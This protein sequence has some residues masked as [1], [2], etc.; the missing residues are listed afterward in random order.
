MDD[1]MKVMMIDDEP[2]VLVHLE[3]LVDWRALGFRLCG[4]FQDC[5][6]A[7]AQ[8]LRDPP[9][10]L[11]IDIS[12]PGISGLD[13]IRKL[14]ETGLFPHTVVLTGFAEFTYVQD[15]LRLGVVDYLLKPLSEMK[16]TSILETLK[17]RG[18][19]SHSVEGVHV[20]YKLKKMLAYI[21]EYYS[22]KLSIQTLSEQFSMSATHCSHLFSRELGKSFS[23]YLL[24]VR[25]A[26]AKALLSD[27]DTAVKSIVEMC[28]Y[29]DYVHFHKTFSKHAGMTPAKYRQL[30][31]TGDLPEDGA[32]T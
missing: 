12:M 8:M 21:D 13:F 17:S 19:P 23:Q 22:E 27:T 3:C 18:R 30:H 32:A 1:F 2:W 4:S 14:H 28:G 20:H 16:L 6:S 9:D 10:I 7:L 5:E 26:R 29:T 31:H 25:M 11:F 24:D 15:A